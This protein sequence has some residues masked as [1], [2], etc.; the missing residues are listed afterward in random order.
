MKKLAKVCMV[1]AETQPWPSD[2]RVHAPNYSAVPL[3]RKRCLAMTAPVFLC[4]CKRNGTW[5]ATGRQWLK[6][7]MNTH[8]SS[9]NFVI[10]LVTPENCEPALKD[11]H[12]ANFEPKFLFNFVSG[13]FLFFLY[14]L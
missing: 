12:P 7:E 3:I 14:M 6:R 2:S 5:G 11:D 13:D 1:R 4:L 10:S 8:V 9:Q